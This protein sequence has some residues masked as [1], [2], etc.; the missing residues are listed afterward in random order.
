MALIANIPEREVE[1][2]AALARPVT[3]SLLGHL[4]DLLGHLT[5]THLLEVWVLLCQACLLLKYCLGFLHFLG[6]IYSLLP[7]L[8]RF[9][10]GFL[11]LGPEHVLRSASHILHSLGL[12]APV[13]LFAA[14]EVIVLALGAF[15]ASVWELEIVGTELLLVG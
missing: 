13:A 7:V 5:L 15:P 14:L 12:L 4:L 9:H 10:G 3:N 11:V 8:N 1:V 6:L 2:P